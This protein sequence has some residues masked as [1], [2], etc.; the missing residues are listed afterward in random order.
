MTVLLA[1]GMLL[2]A[3]P[4]S[5]FATEVN[6]E[7]EPAVEEVAVEETAVSEETEAPRETESAVSGTDE[8]TVFSVAEEPEIIQ[9]TETETRIETEPET[10][11]TAVADNEETVS[12]APLETETVPEEEDAASGGN[13]LDDWTDQQI[14]AEADRLFGTP[15]SQ[16][17]IDWLVSL[18]QSD[19]NRVINLTGA[20]TQYYAEVPAPAGMFRAASTEPVFRL[21]AVSADRYGD[22]TYAWTGSVNGTRPYY[23]YSLIGQTQG[24]STSWLAMTRADGLAV[25]TLCIDPPAADPHYSGTF[26]AFNSDLDQRAS[27]SDLFTEQAL[28]IWWFSNTTE[29]GWQ[30]RNA[31]YGAVMP[32]LSAEQALIM[33]H[34][35]ISFAYDPNGQWNFRTNFSAASLA[36][37]MDRVNALAQ[38]LH[39]TNSFTFTDDAGASHTFQAPEHCWWTD[40][41]GNQ[42]I[43][44]QVQWFIPGAGGTGNGQR[45]LFATPYFYEVQ[46][47]S[48]FIRVVKASANTTVS[49][50]NPDYYSLSGA[51]YG[52][53]ADSACTDLLATLTTDAAG[54]SNT[55]E[56]QLGAATSMTVYIKEISAPAHFALNST[57]VSQTLTTGHTAEAPL[58]VNASDQPFTGYLRVRKVSSN[59]N[60]TDGNSNYSFDGIQFEVYKDQACT[61]RARNAAGNTFILTG[62][63]NGYTN[64]VNMAAGTYWVREV[65]GSLDGTGYQYN[66]TPAQVTVT[67]NH[68]SSAPALATVS[69]R[70]VTGY[71]Q[72]EKLSANTDISGGNRMYSLAGIQFYVYTNEACTTRARNASGQ[73]FTLTTNAQGLTGTAE[74]ALGTYWVREVESSTGNFRYNSTPVRVPVTSANTA[75]APVKATVEND[76][77]SVPVGILISKLDSETGEPIAQGHGELSGAQYTVRYYDSTAAGGTPLRTW[78]FQTDADGVIRLDEDHLVSGDELYRNK[79]GDPVIPVGTITIKETGHPEGYLPNN[80]TVTIHFAMQADDTVRPDVDFA[81]TGNACDLSVESAEDIMRA[82][83]RFAKL[84]IDGRAMAG[85]P[86]LI[87]RLDEDGNVVESHVI[88]SD[89]NGVVDTSN[90]DKTENAVNSLDRYERN[91]VF[92]DETCLDASVNVWFGEQSAV[93]NDDG[94]LIYANYRITEL[95]CEANAGQDLLSQ[96]LVIADDSFTDGKVYELNA[97]FIDLTVHPESDLI[98]DTTG[99]K[100]A[101][102][103]EEVT[104]TDTFRYDH[105]KTTK[106]YRLETEIFYV[107]RAGG[108]PVSMGTNSISFTPPAVDATS[109]SNGT[110]ANTVA[111]DTSNLNGGTLHA[112]DRLYVTTEEGDEVL[113]LE[114]N[115]DL[116]D[117]RQMLVVPCMRTTATDTAT[118]DH[119]GS[120]LQEASISDV[121]AYENLG[122]G[123]VYTLEGTLRDA[124][125]GEVI[126][127]LDGK[128]CVVT[129]NLRISDRVSSVRDDGSTAVGPVSG[130]VS[131]PAFQFDASDLAGHT[132]VVTEVLYDYDTGNVVLEHNDLT[133]EDQSILYPEVHTSAQ[134]NRTEDHVGSLSDT[135][136]ITDTV[137]LSNL[138]IGKMYTVRGFVMDQETGEAFLDENGG[139]ITSVSEPF[140]ATATEM[141]IDLTFEVRSSQLAGRTLVVFEDLLHN[142]VLVGFHHEIGDED[143]AIHFPEIGTTATAN[144]TG[145]HVTGVNEETTIT[146][147]V[148][149]SNLPTDG[150]EYTVSGYLVDKANGSPILIDGE[151]ITAETAFV[152]E[153]TTGEVEIVFTFDASALA[154]TTVVAFETVTYKG[155]EVAVHADIDD[156]GQTVHIPEIHTHVHDAETEIDHTEAG[157]A[158]LIDTVSYS[159]LLPGREYTVRGCLVDKATGEPLTIDGARIEA[160]TTFTAEESEGSVDVNFTFDA[161]VLAGQTIVAFETLYY[162]GIE[163]AAHADITDEDQTDYVPEIG[164][165][166]IAQDTED[167]ITQAD[168]DVTIIDTVD[169]TGLKPNTKY[170]VTGTLMDQVTGEPVLVNGQPVTNG[171]TFVTP[172]A[173]EGE[174]NVSGSVE[175]VFAFDGSAL[176]GRKVVAFETLYRQDQEVAVHADIQDDAQTVTIPEIRTTAKDAATG[177]HD[178]HLAEEVTI[179]D[180]VLYTGLIPGK[181]YTVTGTLMVKETGKPLMVNGHAVTATE[182]FT[183]E[184]ENGSIEL[185]FV[186]DSTD[187]AGSTVVAFEEIAYEGVTVGVHADLTDEDQSV[188]FPSIATTAT[189]KRSGSHTMTLGTASV[190]TDTISY[191]GLTPGKEYIVRGTVMDKATGQSIGVTA[192]AT[193]TPEA[194]DGQTTLEFRIDTT[195]LHG[196][197]LVVFERL[198]TVSA[199][200]DA[201]EV[202]IAVH[203]D[204]EAGDQTVHVPERPAKPKTGDPAMLGVFATACGTA[205]AAMGVIAAVYKR[206]K[207]R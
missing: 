137:T 152:P 157:A 54:S 206:K 40:E 37:I 176:A 177:D 107:E 188:H 57:V 7:R 84:D 181:T 20:G 99:S 78:V 68:T 114:H 143:Q 15:N 101:T 30:Y 118:G 23:S 41:Q 125:T 105:L 93:N 55:A 21:R 191:T 58:T 194:A 29:P 67:E 166:A 79:D 28:L 124:A 47:H 5:A 134:E 62:T 45:N 195:N 75:S 115:T 127:G 149:Y 136:T 13:S 186:I 144:D 36:P 163:I 85:I 131:M 4:V 202:L 80:E 153:E 132:L 170:V 207:G 33:E 141:T 102:L 169:Y 199:N 142:D 180:E 2:S 35:L 167:H 95:R 111:I 121:V 48:A 73:T 120:A 59:A 150:R 52:V 198:Y 76:P 91:G 112:V 156:E 89:A 179:V 203:E 113:L 1:V 83:L 162:N 51:R 165:T 96:D 168:A 16:G 145:E 66:A 122:S 27:H 88:V 50:Q 161:S 92:T 77:G 174:V 3:L 193:F 197:S 116:S 31:I 42:R 12:E 158:I 38:Q 178:G 72:A 104:V 81:R 160:E 108:D 17:Y 126:M 39:D 164:T 148:A 86:F 172:A 185:T 189:D 44:N 103:G 175:V 56:I 123:M 146:D 171:A 64:T 110:I 34:I 133:D 183:A 65:R 151:P 10:E 18:E 97:V 61:T 187:L 53:Y 46:D 22:G 130:E 204:M 70:P 11:S 98:D 135:V 128:P 129:K 139:K 9:E 60:V 117:E 192:E 190:L 74:M 19:R 71:L 8:E 32:N 82:D 90:R 138:I 196:H 119:V 6:E 94:S 25:S 200:T 182:E 140:E 106:T 69:D 63:A 26:T 155:V 205:A 14:I 184:R 173:E 87:S 49:N 109:T 43:N 24:W 201:D 159:H 147:V 154:G 100:S